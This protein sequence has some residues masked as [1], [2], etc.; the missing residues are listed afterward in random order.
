[1]GSNPWT[2]LLLFIAVIAGGAIVLGILFS[3]LMGFLGGRFAEK[4][5][6]KYRRKMET[7]LP[8]KN[9]G[10]CGFENCGAYADAVLHNL[11]DENLCPHGSE[12]LPD[13]LENCRKQLQDLMEDPTPPAERKSIWNK[14]Y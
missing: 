14:K 8:G 3:L 2:Y 12:D 5:Q 11:A 10:A 6:E 13:R 9:C 4:T 1:M 7:M